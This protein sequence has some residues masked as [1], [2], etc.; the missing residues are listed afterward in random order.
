MRSLG[1]S[2]DR[3]HSPCD[4]CI[5][6]TEL[7]KAQTDQKLLEIFNGDW[8]DLHWFVFTTKLALRFPTVTSWTSQE[9]DSQEIVEYWGSFEQEDRRKSLNESNVSVLLTIDHYCEF[10]AFKVTKTIEALKGWHWY[11]VSNQNSASHRLGPAP[12]LETWQ[13]DS[14]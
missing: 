7:L 12:V 6:R 14:N 5:C 1:S 9:A 2:P 13:T 11:N 3:L 4:C 10:A 8:V